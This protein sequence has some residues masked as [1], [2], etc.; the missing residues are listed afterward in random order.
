MLSENIEN[1]IS[2]SSSVFVV[3]GVQARRLSHSV[4]TRQGRLKTAWIIHLGK[5]SLIHFP[6]PLFQ[7]TLN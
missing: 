5:G 3:M 2:F 4:C 7:R 1:I 6:F